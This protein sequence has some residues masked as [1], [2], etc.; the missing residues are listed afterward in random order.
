MKS[1][2][3]IAPVL[4]LVSA[5]ALFS[6]C[7]IISSHEEGHFTGRTVGEESLQRIVPGETTEAWVIAT[8]GQPS[9]TEE[10]DEATHILSYHASEIKHVEASLLLI[11]DTSTRVEIDHTVFVECKDGVVQRYWRESDRRSKQRA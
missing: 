7:T 8:L 10:V 1:I 5:S 2:R 3:R 9:R 6:G 4:A 11:F